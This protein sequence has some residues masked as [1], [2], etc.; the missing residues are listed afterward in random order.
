ML[1]TRTEM[2]IDWPIAI[3]FVIL[4]GIMAAVAI[5]ALTARQEG[6]GAGDVEPREDFERGTTYEE[7]QDEGAPRVSHVRDGAEPPRETKGRRA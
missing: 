7:P 4:L 5:V 6:D 3:V 1:A 2:I